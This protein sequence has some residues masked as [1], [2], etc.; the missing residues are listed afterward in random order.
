MLVL[1]VFNR[2]GDICWRHGRRKDFFRGATRGFFPNFSTRAKVVKFGF[3]Y[4]KLRKQSFFAEIFKIQRS[5]VVQ[6]NI[7]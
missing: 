4:S 5:P 1:A 3:S 6:L 7:K 2:A